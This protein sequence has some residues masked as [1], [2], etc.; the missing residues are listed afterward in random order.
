MGGW[1]NKA[2]QELKSLCEFVYKIAQNTDKKQSKT[3]KKQQQQMTTE[4]NI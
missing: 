1:V 3:N 2:F 4:K